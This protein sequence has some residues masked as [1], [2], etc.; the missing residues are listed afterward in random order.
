MPVAPT[1][2]KP[3]AK[4]K[5]KDKPDAKGKGKD[6]PDAKGKGK[7]KPKGKGNYTEFTSMSDVWTGLDLTDIPILIFA[8]VAMGIS[9]LE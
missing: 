4:G 1:K 2:D 5:G 9:L 8:A 7:D 6:K 3:D